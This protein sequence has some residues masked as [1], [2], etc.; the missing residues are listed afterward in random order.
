M[1]TINEST[2]FRRDFRREKRGIHARYLDRLLE[3]MLCAAISFSSTAKSV[4]TCSSSPA[5]ARTAS[6]ASSVAATGCALSVDEMR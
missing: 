1:R 5:S 4:I 6:S 3:E 2:R